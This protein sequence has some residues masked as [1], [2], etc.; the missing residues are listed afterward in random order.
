MK[1]L[2]VL[3]ALLAGMFGKAAKADLGGA[4][5]TGPSGETSS[6]Q[7]YQAK[8]GQALD[9]CEVSFK[10]G[11]LMINN[12]G[13]IYSDQYIS[14]V[15]ARTCRQR[16][17]AL[18]WVKSCFHNQYDYDFTITYR[19][20]IGEKRSALI[21]FRPGYF[22]QGMEA[23][24]SFQRDLQIWIEDV[25]RPIGPS[26]KIEGE[27]KSRPSSRPKPNASNGGCKPPL[28]DFLCDWDQYLEANPNVK[29]WAEANPAMATKERIRLGIPDN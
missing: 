29:A 14:V 24:S 27:A 15:T 11:K 12:K 8:C 19:S 5:I 10:N 16:S 22:L 7:T 25:L 26:I 1:G 2:L 3:V 23:H 4:D 28:S 18:P 9:K 13:G 17:I 21:A 6:G 20:E